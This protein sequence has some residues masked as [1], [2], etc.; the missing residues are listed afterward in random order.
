MSKLAISEKLVHATYRWVESKARRVLREELNAREK[1]R[2]QE[3]TPETRGRIQRI[4]TLGHTGWKRPGTSRQ[5]GGAAT[6]QNLT[7]KEGR[8]KR[9]V[10]A[11]CG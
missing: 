1:E 11:R 8:N 5:K 6:A 9:E 4:N 7:D 3:V 2:R 10:I